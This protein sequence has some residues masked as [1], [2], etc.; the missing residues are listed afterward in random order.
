MNKQKAFTLIE[1]AIVLLVIGILAGLMLRNVGVYSI[2]ARDAKRK[3][4][5]RNLSVNLVQYNAAYGHYPTGTNLVS[6]LKSIGVINLPSTP[7][8][9]EYYYYYPCSVSGVSGFTHFILKTTFE[10]SSSTNPGLYADSYNSDSLPS[11]WTCNKADAVAFSGDSTTTV[12]EDIK[13][14][15]S[16]ANNYCIAQ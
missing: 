1:L 10:Q 8:S 12:N 11:G 14:S 13:C 7:R 15:N 16:T 6:A 2:Q 9:G 5:L 3:G 4:D